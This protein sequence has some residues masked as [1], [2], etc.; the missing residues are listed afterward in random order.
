ME[1]Q[2]FIDHGHLTYLPNVSIDCAVFGFHDN[3]LKILLL[4]WKHLQGWSLPGGYMKRSEEAEQAA[5]RL[6]KER[7]GLEKIF[8]QQYHTFTGIDRTKVPRLGLKNLG[9]SL[10]IKIDETNWLNDRV[11]SIGFYALVEYS[12]VNPMPDSFT[13]SCEWRSVDKL[14]PMMFDHKE[15]VE[16]ALRTLRLQLNYQPVGLNLLPAK[17]TMGELQRLY[18]TLLNH[19]L[20]RGNF[21]KKMLATGILRKTGERPTG[22]AHKTPHLYSFNKN[23]YAKSFVTGI[24][25]SGL[26]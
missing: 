18:E 11:V 3:S 13:E 2:E 26:S 16:A 1:L 15:M 6:L 23:H 21:R 19:P 25:F 9:D 4:K 17:F 12:T 14:P 20:D 10:G 5:M 24:N 22:K 8:L 7:T